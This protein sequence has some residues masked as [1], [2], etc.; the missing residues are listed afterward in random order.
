MLWS[1]LLPCHT[2]P[3]M[4]SVTFSITPISILYPSLCP[5]KQPAHWPS[6]PAPCIWCVSV[7][8]H[9]PASPL[10]NIFATQVTCSRTVTPKPTASEN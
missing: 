5:S 3:T 8:P 6:T 4:I 1:K 7:P 9:L 2:K 10:L